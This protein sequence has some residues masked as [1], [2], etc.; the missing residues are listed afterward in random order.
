[1]D[2]EGPTSLYLDLE[3]LP[4]EAQ[5][6]LLLELSF[7]VYIAYSVNSLPHKH[8]DLGSIPRTHVE[9][10]GLSCAYNLNAE[11]AEAG[12]SLRFQGQP[13]YPHQ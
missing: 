11:E 1:M 5:N 12:G 9:E 6:E 3:A 7:G 10:M 13:A 8:E 2:P 4:P